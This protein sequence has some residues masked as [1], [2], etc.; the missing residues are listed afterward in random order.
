MNMFTIYVY[1]SEPVKKLDLK[2][3]IKENKIDI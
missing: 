1:M 3:L 2:K